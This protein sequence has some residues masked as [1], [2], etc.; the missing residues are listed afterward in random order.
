MNRVKKKMML[1]GIFALASM[2][3]FASNEEENKNIHY[4]QSYKGNVE[5][6]CGVKDTWSFL[7]SHGYSFGNGLYLG[8]GSGFSAEFLPEYDSNPRV[9]LP[10]FADLKY[11]FCN[12]VV[13]PFVGVR[14]GGYAHVNS[15]E[16]EGVRVFVNPAV[17]LEIKRFSIIIGYE[18]QHNAWGFEQGNN[19]H[20]LR[21]GV[22]IMF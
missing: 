11:S 7:S 12:S 2:N 17:G 10:L 15:E 21:C 18:Y 5:L 3:V 19:K 4:E 13:S 1:L 16:V 22:A 9:L 20:R 6:S 14:A 8:G